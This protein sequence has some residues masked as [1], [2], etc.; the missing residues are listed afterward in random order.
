MKKKIL[1]GLAGTMLISSVGFAAP[2][3]DLAKG[4]TVIGYNYHSYSA[5]LAGYD[6]GDFNADG[7]HIEHGLTDQIT[8]G[9]ETSQGKANYLYA[10]SDILTAKVT[11]NDIYLAYKPQMSGKANVQ[12]ILGSRSYKENDSENYYGTIYPLGSYSENHPLYGVQ[13]STPL[14]DKV[15]G[16]AGVSATKIETEWKIGATYAVTPQVN[17]DL[18]YTNKKFD[19]LYLNLKGVGFGLNYKF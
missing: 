2:V 8:L 12:L 19:D 16:Y 11:F 10:P 14:G 4:E 18:N 9:F 1:V 6:F 3:V 7:F 17:L 13:A 5:D 15:N